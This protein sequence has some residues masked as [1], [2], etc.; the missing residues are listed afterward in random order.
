MSAGVYGS[1]GS[2]SAS[3]GGGQSRCRTLSVVIPCYNEKSTIGPVIEAVLAAD[4]SGLGR[5]VVIVDDCSTDGTRELVRRLENEY[6]LD[7]RGTVKVVCHDVNRGKGAALRT[8]FSHASGEVILVQDADLEYDPRDYPALLHP[9][10]AGR[11]DMV[12]GNRFHGGPH[13]VLYFW[14]YHANRLLTLLCGVLTDLNVSDME[15][16]YKLFR[17]EVLEQISLR[18]NRFGFEPEVIIKTARLRCRVYEVPVAYHGRTYA[19][20]KKIGWKDGL[21]AIFHL[22]RYGLFR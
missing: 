1:Q 16:G 8:A 11:A 15:V 2:A 7:P 20:G 13:R 18:S 22:L 6:R 4:T 21:A 12:L 9:I 14:H 5:E 3:V 17:R 10:L 19:E